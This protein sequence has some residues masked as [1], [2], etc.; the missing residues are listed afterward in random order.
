MSV[1]CAGKLRLRNLGNN[2]ILIHGKK[3]DETARV[4]QEFKDWTTSWLE[5]WRIWAPADV[6]HSRQVWTRW[7]GIPL[8]AWS[9]RFFGTK[10]STIGKMIRVHDVTTS[11]TS[12]DAAFIKVSTGLNTVD[13]VLKCKIDGD[14]F[15]IR[16]E[17][18]RCSD[19]EL[20]LFYRG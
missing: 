19:L 12:L 16:I 18:L 20:D 7:V 11:R 14:L 6:C 13:K 2:R 17:E 15:V 1:E 9:N 10:N 4:L 5:W 8:H 3:K